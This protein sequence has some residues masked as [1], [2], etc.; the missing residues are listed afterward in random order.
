ML[1]GRARGLDDL[2]VDHVW[3]GHNDC[4]HVVTRDELPPVVDRVAKAEVEREP[5]LV[6]ARVGTRDEHRVGE[7]L[8][9]EGRDAQVRARVRLAHPAEPDDTDADPRPH[10]AIIGTRGSTGIP[11]Q[12]ER[13]QA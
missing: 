2:D 4:V 7:P 5:A 8:A 6:A 10:A 12:L 9:K 3:R 1:A 13:T 11:S